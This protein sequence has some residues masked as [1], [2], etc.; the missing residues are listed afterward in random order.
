LSEAKS[1][2]GGLTTH[3]ERSSLHRCHACHRR[4]KCHDAIALTSMASM[5]R[6]QRLAPEQSARPGL[7]V[8]LLREVSAGR[9]NGHRRYH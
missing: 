7:L 6:P 8:Q 4:H 2:S 1:A 9:S 5:G 3:R